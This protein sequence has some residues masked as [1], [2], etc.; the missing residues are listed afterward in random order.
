MADS[1]IHV[2]MADGKTFSVTVQCPAKG[3]FV[4]KAIAR[5]SGISPNCQQL[6]DNLG[7]EI[8]NDDDI[9]DQNVF[10]IVNLCQITQDNVFMSAPAEKFE[11]DIP[12]IGLEQ[13]W[14]KKVYGKV[15]DL[16]RS[17]WLAKDW[18]NFLCVLEHVDIKFKDAGPDEEVHTL[19]LQDHLKTRFAN[20]RA[21]LSD[22]VKYCENEWS[23][24]EIVKSIHECR[25]INAGVVD[26]HTF[27]DGAFA[28]KTWFMVDG[29]K[30]LFRYDKCATR[31]VDAGHY[32]YI[33]LGI[34]PS[35][36]SFKFVS[37][38]KEE[39]WYNG[40]KRIQK[41]QEVAST[42]QFVV[43]K[44]PTKFRSAFNHVELINVHNHLFR[45]FEPEWRVRISKF[46]SDRFESEGNHLHNDLWGTMRFDDEKVCARAASLM[47]HRKK[48]IEYK[49]KVADQTIEKKPKKPTGKTKDQYKGV[50]PRLL[51]ESELRQYCQVFWTSCCFVWFFL[52][53]HSLCFN[54]WFR[55][56]KPQRVK[57]QK[58]TRDSL[59]TRG[60]FKCVVNKE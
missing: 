54:M 32:L 6:V 49:K 31:F 55:R 10:L 3:L 1:I 21:T 12:F 47:G 19:L 53:F 41:A 13:E 18:Q 8:S 9:S 36:I 50:E 34:K 40:Q 7:Q 11:T 42:N 14:E 16:T 48:M 37:T 24:I 56:R 57:M 29:D 27:D 5:V 44:I 33:R 46:K 45:K 25:K 28:H 58:D 17:T 52:A 51:S 30:Y 22:V 26:L 20:E 35:E 38:Q 23:I 43:E 15:S 59:H 60:N 2:E 4:K 39:D